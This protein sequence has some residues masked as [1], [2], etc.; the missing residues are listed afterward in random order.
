M[1]EPPVRQASRSQ[2]LMAATRAAHDGL[3]ARI[4]SA[5]PFRDRD[6]YGRL[7]RMQYRFHRHIDDLYRMPLPLP[8]ALDLRARRRL[9][10]I[11]C[12]LDDLGQPLPADEVRPTA[13]MDAAT[14]IGWLWVAEGSNLGAASLLKRAA[15]LGLDAAFGARHLAGHPEGR[16]RQWKE[17]TAA[18]NGLDLDEQD[19]ARVLEGACEAF[20]H[21]RMLADDSF[22]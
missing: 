17:F 9:D 7:L 22:A 5:E 19:D 11:L 14:A 20:A 13:Q 6:S 15:A 18:V 16:A 2:R 3:D 4:I 1:I 8:P 12:D 10:H 21:V